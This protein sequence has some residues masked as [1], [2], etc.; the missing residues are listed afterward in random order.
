MPVFF[1]FFLFCWRLRFY[2]AL[3]NLIYEAGVSYVWKERRPW[4]R[5]TYIIL[6]KSDLLN[7]ADCLTYY[8]KTR[9]LS[10][11]YAGCGN[12]S[13]WSCLKPTFTCNTVMW[14]FMV[15]KWCPAGYRLPCLW[16]FFIVTLN[17]NRLTKNMAHFFLPGDCSPKLVNNI[18]AYDFPSSI[19]RCSISHRKIIRIFYLFI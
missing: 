2:A 1:F 17:L 19:K 18:P 5:P 13:L 14:S 7:T 9:G 11:I 4:D 15:L 12:C 8:C 16:A 3:L 6:R 10:Q